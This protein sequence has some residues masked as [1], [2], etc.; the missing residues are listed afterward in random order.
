MAARLKLPT[1]G[2][3]WTLVGQLIYSMLVSLD[4]Y[5][6]DANGDFS[7]AQPTEQA[8]TKITTD[9]ANVGTFLYGRRM[10]EIMAVWETDP[11]LAA[12]SPE[13]ARFGQTWQAAKKIVYSQ[14]LKTTQSDRTELQRA[15]EPEDIRA[16]KQASD[17]DLT[18]DG[19]T[20]AAEAFRH[21]LV[22]RV[23]VLLCPVII[24]SGLGFWPRHRCD[25]NLD[26]VEHLDG[27]IVY[28]KYEV[29]HDQ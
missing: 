26:Q 4:G 12:S 5:V 13:S 18:I 11:Q 16:L 10:Y 25:L 23:F 28:L 2:P 8:L 9:M 19:P 1:D 17:R 3:G 15:F 7:W 24:G 22:D 29:V 14:Q 21:K 20:L 6:A 27:G